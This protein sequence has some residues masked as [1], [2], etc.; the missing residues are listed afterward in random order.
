MKKRKRVYERWGFGILTWNDACSLWRVSSLRECE[1]AR[2]E[3]VGMVYYN[4]KKRF[5]IV[6]QNRNG[7]EFDCT[8]VPKEWTV[9]FAPLK[10]ET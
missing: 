3:S 5:F 8:C 7:D 4:T 10:E 6:V 1:L 9:V 2:Q